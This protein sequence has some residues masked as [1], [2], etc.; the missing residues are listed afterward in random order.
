MKRSE[1]LFTAAK[2]PL[3]YLSLI[4]AALV[5]YFIRYLP[6]VQSIRPVIFDLAFKE[7][8]S[9]AAGIAIVWLVIFALAGLYNIGGIKKIWEEL[10]RIFVA[11]SAGLAIVLA[12]MVFS[13]FLFDSRFIILATWLLAIIF[14]SLERLIIQLAQRLAYKAGFGVHRI[15]IIGDGHI[16]QELIKEFA[17]RLTLGYRVVGQFLNFDQAAEEKLKKLAAEDGLDEIIQ[18]NPN[19]DTK[20][21][22]NLINF[23]D[24][25]HLDFKYTADLLG[26]Q[27]TNLEVTTY[28]GMPLVEVKKT[29]LDGWGKIYKRIFDIIASIF[30]IVL[31]SP[32]M[33]ITAVA[34]KLDSKGPILFKYKRTGQFGRPFTYFKFRSMVKDAHQYRFDQEFLAQQENLRA[35]TPMMKFKKDPRI[36]RVGKF[37]RRFSI[38]ELPELFLT[39][40]NKMSLVGPRPHEIEEVGKYQQHH[41]K[42]L[43]IKPGITGLAQVSGRSDLNFEQEVKLDTF[44][45]ENWSL[46]LDLQILLKT[47]LA[48]IRRRRSE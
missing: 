43:T 34:I 46:G 32:V 47:P 28:A 31:L 3:D 27:L 15:V 25:Y 44:Y 33:L 10:G 36:T 20:Q 21:T 39:L 5:A 22:T 48:V 6:S 30:L 14:V 38:D 29:R 7:Y 37:I 45:I 24:E 18:I 8:F 12:V 23:A 9:L 26:T 17:K 11:C 1:L 40:S 16:A 35:G 42:I 4:F 19:L 2:P 41:K 13:R